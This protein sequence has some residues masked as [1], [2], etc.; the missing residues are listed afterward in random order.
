ME[1]EKEEE[2]I[3]YLKSKE[4]QESFQKQVE[5]D[6]WGKGRPKIYMDKDKNIVEHWKDG[7]INIRKHHL[8]GKDQ[9]SLKEIK[10]DYRIVKIDDVD[11]I[12]TR[13]Y[14]PDRLNIKI[15]NGVI[16]EVYYG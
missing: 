13:D 2:S 7:T 14:R 8:I 6:T 1:D 12:I 16:T 5:E 15:Q 4:F 11:F 10:E 3:A 9:S